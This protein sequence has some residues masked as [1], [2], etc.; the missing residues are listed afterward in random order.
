MTGEVS[1][2]PS[3]V[4]R[5]ALVGAGLVLVVGAV[6]S[7]SPLAVLLAIGLCVVLV[8]WSGIAVTSDDRVVVIRNTWRTV[9]IPWDQVQG[10][11]ILGNGV[12]IVRK[13]EESQRPIQVAAIRSMAV[14]PE[15]RFDALQT[16]VQRLSAANP[17]GPTSASAG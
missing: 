15:A 12:A 6:L 11:L 14:S 2:R 16:M 10:W 17:N 4:A 13:G 3:G 5:I 1:V 7:R 9:E 8:R